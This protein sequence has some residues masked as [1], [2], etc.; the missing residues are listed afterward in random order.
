MLLEA[1]SAGKDL[2][3]VH[4]IAS[5]LVR[6]G[7]GGLVRRL[8]LGHALEQAGKTLHWKYAE[9]TAVLE[10]HQRARHALEKLG[11]T[12]VKLG[13]VLATRVDLFPPEWIAE[14]ELLQD[15]APPLDFEDL[16]AQLEEDL[17]GPPEEIF[18]EFDTEALAAASIAQVHRARLHDG[19][20]VIV[21]IRRPGIKRTVEAD[22]RL[23]KRL[24]RIAARDNPETQR[25]RPEEV[26]HQFILSLRRELDL[27]HECRNAVRVAENLAAHE[28]IVV[29]KVYW[30][31]TGERVNVQEYIDGIPG[32]DLATLETAGLDRRLIASRGAS[33]VLRMVLVDGFFHADPHPGNIFFL[34]DNRIAL[35]DFGMTGHL[36]EERRFQVIELLHGMVERDT[37]R[38]CEVLLEWS[39]NASAP[40]ERLVADICAFL[41][42][43]H[44]L[45]LGQVNLPAMIR[46]M[47][48]MLRD[49]HLVLP[50]DL[51]M[52]F[53]VFLTLDGFCR[54]LN[55]DFDLIAEARPFVRHAMI[56]R[57][58]PAEVARRGWHGLSGMIDLLTGLPKDL[59][60]LVRAA[61]GGALRVHIQVDELEHFGDRLDSAVSRLTIGMITAAFIIGT[62][63]MLSVTGDTEYLAMS[64]L[65]GLGFSLAALGGVWV[66]FSIWR[67]RR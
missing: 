23:M 10:P 32:R 31:W 52:M 1:I 20:Q 35:I 42:Q 50:A 57:Y 41:D 19:T 58:T 47:M 22:L 27:A 3:R 66:L 16:R 4:E 55:P 25:F 37:A 62:S 38:V 8:G 2:G 9:E 67:G 54:Q 29:P 63:I 34:P 46:D 53:K 48:A 13:Q 18:A 30:Q 60:R 65:A 33:A 51:S 59:R 49:N 21:K 11:P 6:C 24:A 12:F 14:F 15:A 43:Y 26:V 5:I 45:A 7:F 39:N 17:G 40:S 36:A 61:R 64:I 28:H 44:G 56:M